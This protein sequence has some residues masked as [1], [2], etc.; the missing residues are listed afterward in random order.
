MSV[1]VPLSVKDENIKQVEAI[2]KACKVANMN[3]SGVVVAK[4]IECF[5]NGTLFNT[6]VINGKC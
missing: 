5:E 1:Q 2:Q 3:F 6:E 4:I